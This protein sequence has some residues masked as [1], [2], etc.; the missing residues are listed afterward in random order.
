MWKKKKKTHLEKSSAEDLFIHLEII[1]WH[2]DYP[3]FAAFQI[4]HRLC[5]KNMEEIQQVTQ[6]QSVEG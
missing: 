3:Q 1:W 2:F 5:K 4:V 6:V